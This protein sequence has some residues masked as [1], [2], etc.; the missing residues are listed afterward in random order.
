MREIVRLRGNRAGVPAPLID[1]LMQAVASVVEASGD[2]DLV[3]FEV[4]GPDGA[5]VGRFEGYIALMGGATRED[6]VRAIRERANGE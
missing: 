3:A 6:V 1:G 4:N 2:A 5:I